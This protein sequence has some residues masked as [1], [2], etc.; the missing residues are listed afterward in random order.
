MLSVAASQLQQQQL[1]LHLHAHYPAYGTIKSPV[2]GF[3]HKTIG[4]RVDTPQVKTLFQIM[5]V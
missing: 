3:P 2:S 1:P 5:D 4:F